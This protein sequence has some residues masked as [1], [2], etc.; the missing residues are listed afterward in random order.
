MKRKIYRQLLEWK[1]NRKGETALMIEGARRVGKSY[2]VEEFAKRE[3]RSYILIDFNTADD[4]IKSLFS[5]YL[6]KLDTLFMYLSNYT[7]TRLYE[8]ESLIIF[9]EVQFLSTR[10][11]RNQVSGEG[12]SLRLHRNRLAC[13]HQEERKRYIDTIGGRAA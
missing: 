1:Q 12:R 5:N 2:I 10:P 9:D 11:C 13:V 4:D 8:R 7:N 3:Y 6:N